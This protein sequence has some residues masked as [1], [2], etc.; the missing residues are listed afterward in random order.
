MRYLELAFLLIASVPAQAEII[1]SEQVET[2]YMGTLAAN[3]PSGFIRMQPPDQQTVL[4]A[5]RGDM[6]CTIGFGRVRTDA[7]VLSISLRDQWFNSVRQLAASFPI[8]SISEPQYASN[9]GGT[10]FYIGQA[11]VNSPSG[12]LPLLKIVAQGNRGGRAVAT[13]F[14]ADR[15]TLSLTFNATMQALQSMTVDVQSTGGSATGYGF[16]NGS[17]E[18]TKRLNDLNSSFGS[19]FQSRQKGW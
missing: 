11:M 16:P 1:S 18:N 2:G 15:A 8:T 19:N 17:L 4:F 12:A 14:C 6:T 5:Y 10:S 3:L 13:Y 7:Q 9:N